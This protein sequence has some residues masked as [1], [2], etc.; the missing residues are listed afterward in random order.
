[1]LPFKNSFHIDNAFYSSTFIDLGIIYSIIVD[2][3]N[4]LPIIISNIITII[5]SEID[6]STVEGINRSRDLVRKAAMKVSY[7]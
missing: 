4:G 5:I 7:S 6:F 2:I 3:R 1:M